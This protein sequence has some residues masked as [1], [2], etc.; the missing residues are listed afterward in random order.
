MSVVIWTRG[1]SWQVSI[2]FNI[3][4]L[5]LRVATVDQNL[6]EPVSHELIFRHFKQNKVEIACAIKMPFPFLMSLRDHAFISEQ[7]YEVSGAN[8]FIAGDQPVLCQTSGCGRQAGGPPL[9][10]DLTSLRSSEV[11]REAVITE[12]IFFLQ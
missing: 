2:Y 4:S 11:T 1:T 7:K 10:G 8:S 12:T 6:G 3:V 5:L 9:S